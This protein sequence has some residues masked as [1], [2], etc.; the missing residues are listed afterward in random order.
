[1]IIIKILFFERAGWLALWLA[2]FNSN[3]A[4]RCSSK[5]LRRGV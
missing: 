3:H 4:L 5:Q 1:V 2:V